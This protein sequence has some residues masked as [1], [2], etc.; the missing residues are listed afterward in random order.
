ML[1]LC[2]K[3]PSWRFKF[4][5]LLRHKKS[6]YARNLNWKEGNKRRKVFDL[7]P[8]MLGCIL[9]KLGLGCNAAGRRREVRSRSSV[10]VRTHILFAPHSWLLHSWCACVKTPSVSI[11]EPLKKDH[12]S[13]ER[14]NGMDG[15]R[16]LDN[17]SVCRDA[18]NS[19]HQKT[20]KQKHW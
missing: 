2:D 9:K 13:F 11:Y 7:P 14:S 4:L 8:N 17:P 5:P 18:L 20:K 16:W 1:P 3:I 15:Q 12:K 19:F 10:R 6:K